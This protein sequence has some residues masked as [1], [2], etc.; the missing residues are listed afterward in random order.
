MYNFLSKKFSDFIKGSGN[1]HMG[2]KFRNLFLEICGG[3]AKII[4][5]SG[6]IDVRKRTTWSAREKSFGKFRKESL[7]TGISMRLEYT[8]DF[9]LCG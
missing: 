3:N 7:G 1:I 4:R 6:C 9:F 8:P 5:F 2:S